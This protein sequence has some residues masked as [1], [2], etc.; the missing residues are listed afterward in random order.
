VAV[1]VRSTRRR[2]LAA[3]LVAAALVVPT[4]SADADGTQGAALTMARTWGVDNRVLAIVNVGSSVIIGGEFTNVIDPDGNQYPANHVAKFDP[5]TGAF[6]T[7]WSLNVDNSVNSMAVDGDTLYLGGAFQYVNGTLHKFLAAVSLSTGALQ[8]GFATQATRSV[9]AMALGDGFLYVGGAFPSLRDATGFKTVNYLGRVNKST[10]AIDVGWSN[11]VVL[12]GRVWSLLAHPNG[13]RLY[14]GGDFLSIN[15]DP[16]RRGMAA[17]TTSSPAAIDTGYLSGYTNQTSRAP[18]LGMDLEGDNL[19]LAVGGSGGACTLQNATTGTDIWSKHGTGN[20]VGVAFFGPYSY[21]GGHFSG[22]GSFDGQTREKVAAIETTTGTLQAW[23]PTVNSALGVWSMASTDSALMIGGDFT[24]SDGTYQSHFGFYPDLSAVSVPTAPTGL[25][26][27]SGDTSVVLS[28][29]TPS[30]DGGSAIQRYRVYRGPTADTLVLIGVTIQASYSDTMVTNGE[31]YVYAVQAR[32]GVGDSVLSATVGGDPVGG[33]VTPPSAPLSF[34]AAGVVG[35]ASLTWVAPT[36]D[37]GSPI[38]G[39]QI[40]RSTSTGTEVPYLVVPATPTWYTD[41]NVVVGTR[42]YYR[43]TALNALGES[44]PSLESSAAPNTGVPG[45]PT[46]SLVS[47]APHAISLAWS[48]SNTGASPLTKFVLTRNGI[49]IAVLGPTV[50][51][52]KDATAVAGT[53]NV[54]Q[55]KATN[56]YGTGK[57]S[58]K[59]TVIAP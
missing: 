32:N 28:W 31:H 16:L 55:V 17:V 51:S 33:V 48:L 7:S 37:G 49:R 27:V 25:T 43:V 22:P 10:G 30:S 6:D 4:V 59:I 46:L 3:A 2:I 23:A 58:N 20:V 5:A 19:L 34:N 44:V 1:R 45:A 57:G 18:V 40:Y 56:S 47:T 13:G 53:T 36:S 26:S 42:Y 14:V 15:A 12:D 21:C 39:Y 52:Y 29:L 54:Y 35:A 24:K 8:T 11:G 9:D 38:T 41:T 50:Y